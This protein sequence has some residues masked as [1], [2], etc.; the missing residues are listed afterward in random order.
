MPCRSLVVLR[1]LFLLQRLRNHRGV[2]DQRFPRLLRA[3]A[4]LAAELT[5]RG[6]ALEGLDQLP[7]C[8]VEPE[9][10][11]KDPRGGRTAQDWSRR[12]RLSS[13]VTVATAYGTKPRSPRSLR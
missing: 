2:R 9:P 11:L 12:Y 1:M 4:Q 6:L 10:Q 3:H 7:A 8:R 13:P 5:N